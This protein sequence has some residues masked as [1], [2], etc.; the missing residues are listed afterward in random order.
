MMSKFV[1]IAEGL[2]G[3]METTTSER[4]ATYLLVGSSRAVLFDAGT[5]LDN[6]R[7]MVAQITDLPITVILS[8][9]H[10]DHVGGAHGFDD[11]IAWQS[12]A[13]KQLQQ[14]GI[15]NEVVSELSGKNYA[16]LVGSV[17]PLPRLR[18]MNST[19][20]IDLGGLVVDVIHTPGHTE[21]S[22]CLSVAQHGWL[23]T[24]DTL[25]DGPLYL[26]S[27]DSSIGDYRHSI[28]RLLNLPVRRVFPGHNNLEIDPE[29]LSSVHNQLN[30]VK[31]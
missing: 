14:V 22:L 29:F 25:Y 31:W 17:A 11:V 28:G 30:E 12:P 18:L 10:H 4:S 6:I 21:D 1:Q 7:S 19:Q 13:T 16:G 8:H 15:S 9:W 23:F 24:G 3:F 27:V 5:G 2:Y 20:R 26:G